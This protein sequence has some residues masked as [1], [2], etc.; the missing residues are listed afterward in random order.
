LSWRRGP[1]GALHE[2]A[3]HVAQL[4]VLDRLVTTARQAIERTVLR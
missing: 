4:A 2:I 1:L 3:G